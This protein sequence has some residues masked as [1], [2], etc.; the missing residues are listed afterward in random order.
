MAPRGWPGLPGFPRGPSECLLST[1]GNTDSWST[2]PAPKSQ[3]QGCPRPSPAET[4]QRRRRAATPLPL[5]QGC[6]L[7]ARVAPSVWSRGPPGGGEAV[8]PGAQRGP[9]A[10]QREG[11]FLYLTPPTPLPGGCVS[12]PSVC[13][14]VRWG[15]AGAVGREAERGG[16]RWGEVGRGTLS[17]RWGTSRGSG[18]RQPGGAGRGTSAAQQV[19]AR[20]PAVLQARARGAAEVGTERSGPGSRGMRGLCAHPERRGLARGAALPVTAG[21]GVVEPRA[22]SWARVGS[23][24]RD[25]GRDARAPHGPARRGPQS[26]LNLPAGSRGLPLCTHDQRRRA[27]IVDAA[28]ALLAWGSPARLCRE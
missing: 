14:Q 5:G 18:G 6:G 7:G 10:S 16:E 3:G 8:T 2:R 24:R 9:A 26:C 13:R 19:R 27:G 25:R 4:G 11:L 23:M 28:K 1:W 12:G 22:A 17:P 15:R 21:L 20:G